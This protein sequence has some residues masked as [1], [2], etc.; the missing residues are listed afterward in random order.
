M[1]DKK[2]TS[3]VDLRRGGSSSSLYT[4]HNWNQR[5]NEENWFMGVIFHVYFKIQT[6]H[7]LHLAPSL[8]LCFCFDGLNDIAQLWHLFAISTKEH[9]STQILTNTKTFLK[10]TAAGLLK[11]MELWW[12]WAKKVPIY[13]IVPLLVFK[14][15]TYQS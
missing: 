14:M 9:A 6:C 7:L 2:F 5:G 3:E 12:A 10:H 4:S 1:V 11:Q 15:Q 13:L 8:S